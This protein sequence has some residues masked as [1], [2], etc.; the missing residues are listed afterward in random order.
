MPHE[1][2]LRLRVLIGLRVA[3]LVE[4]DDLADLTGLSDVQAVRALEAARAEHEVVR[5]EGSRTSGWQLTDE[6]EPDVRRQAQADVQDAGATAV[7]AAATETFV[8]LDDQVLEVVRHW[9]WK[10]GGPRPNDHADEQYDHKVVQSLVDV[11]HDVAEVCA[12]VSAAVDRFE[13]Y[14]VHLH[15]AVEHVLA[16]RSDWIEGDQV[17]S[18]ARVAGWLRDDLLISTGRWPDGVRGR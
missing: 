5:M 13:P 14:G 15:A 1:S 6:A 3:G 17:R 2:P 18:Y 7:L 4:T 11:H 9:S 10:D 16:G 12:T 8:G